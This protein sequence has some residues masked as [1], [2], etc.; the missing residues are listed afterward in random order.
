MLLEFYDR[1]EIINYI[2]IL[3]DLLG[4]KQYNGPKTYSCKILIIYR[5][6][7]KGGV[8]ILKN[9]KSL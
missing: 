3:R 4:G 9:F 2:F 7:H 1:S 8:V 6:V 5:K